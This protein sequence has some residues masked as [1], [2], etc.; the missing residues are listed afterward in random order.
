[1]ARKKKQKNF[2]KFYNIEDNDN[3][4]ELD[5]QEE[6]QT[7]KVKG[8][9]RKKDRFEDEV[10]EIVVDNIDSEFIEGREL[11]VSMLERSS[12][13]FDNRDDIQ[14]L[15]DFTSEDVDAL[16]T[17]LND[18]VELLG[19]VKADSTKININNYDEELSYYVTKETKGSL[20]SGKKSG[21]LKINIPMKVDSGLFQV[22]DDLGKMQDAQ[23]FAMTLGTLPENSRIHFHISQV[24][25]STDDLILKYKAKLDKTL[26]AYENPAV[27]EKLVEHFRKREEKFTSELN[28]T[29]ELAIYA[30]YEAPLYLSYE[31]LSDEKKVAETI[32]KDY[33]VFNKILQDQLGLGIILDYQNINV[34]GIYSMLLFSLNQENKFFKDTQRNVNLKEVSYLGEYTDATQLLSQTSKAFENMNRLFEMERK[35]KISL[36]NDQRELLSILENQNEYAISILNDLIRNRAIL[37]EKEGKITKLLLPNTLKE[38]EG[39]E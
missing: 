35:N 16:N 37:E 2:D 4:N 6:V 20:L 26:M 39:G 30:V 12:D 31:E 23:N 9:R 7:K 34:K 21:S 25:L 22:K 8:K 17:Y 32:K 19:F 27:K 36:T 29:Y 1:M 28:N 33:R 5:T 13:E 3:L 10:E 18:I 24:P 38:L 14:E 15:S 11:G